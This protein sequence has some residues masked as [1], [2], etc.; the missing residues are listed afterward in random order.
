MK[1][2]STIKVDH[3]LLQASLFYLILELRKRTDEDVIITIYVSYETSIMM[4]VA[5]THSG[6][7]LSDQD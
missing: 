4:Q 7:E 6:S 1:G 3:F 5:C 2:V